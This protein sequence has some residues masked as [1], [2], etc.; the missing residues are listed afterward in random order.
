MISPC[1]G[2]AQWRS[3]YMKNGHSAIWS[4]SHIKSQ[5]SWAFSG[6]ITRDAESGTH[7]T[8]IYLRDATVGISDLGAMSLWSQWWWTP[9]YVRKCKFRSML[10]TP[11]QFVFWFITVFHVVND[12]LTTRIVCHQFLPS[13][14]IDANGYCPRS[15]QPPVR[16]PVC[17]SGKTLML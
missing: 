8:I 1:F 6:I 3:K 2:N 4:R 17:L 16:S 13:T 15:M 5:V 7:S 10:F 9:Y 14:A 11:H 12:R